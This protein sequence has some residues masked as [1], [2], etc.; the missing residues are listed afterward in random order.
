ME[1]TME[2]TS[3]LIK[4]LRDKTGAGMMDCKRA[5]EATQGNMESAIEY[6]RKK[7]AA[8]AQKRADRSA[9]EGMIVTRVSPDGKTGVIVEINCETDF[10][11]K[12]DDFTAFANAVAEAAAVNKPKTI[13]ELRGLKVASGRTV[14]DMMNDLLAK[15]GEKIDVRRFSI[16]EAGTGTVFSYT[17]L[18]NKIG[19]LV[20]CTS[21][22]NDAAGTAVG[23]DI[24]MQIAAMN[25][26][27]IARE[28][29]GKGVVARELEIYRTQAANEGKPAAIQEKIAL[30]RLEKFYQEVCL[31]E[32]IFIRDGAK[33]VKEHLSDAG[34]DASVVRFHRYHLGEEAR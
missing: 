23:R 5:L 29:I 7:G 9:K 3:T 26:M 14:A 21:L 32:Q 20:E 1:E 11:G 2:I 24:A 10:V 6:L 34:H 4:Q 18:G 33:T 15:V 28:E 30:G 19:V 27:V 16:V 12:S 25:P 22:A 8:V 13:E 31:L 17:H